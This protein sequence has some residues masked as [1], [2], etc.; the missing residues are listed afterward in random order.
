MY[1]GA[2]LLLHWWMHIE[3]IKL[4][5]IYKPIASITRLHNV[6]NSA[7]GALPDTIGA[8]SVMSYLLVPVVL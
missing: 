2:C 6:V 8:C 4:T 7:T 5:E 1:W 3:S